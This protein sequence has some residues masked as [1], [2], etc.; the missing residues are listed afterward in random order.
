MVFLRPKLFNLL[1]FGVGVG[2]RHASDFM[3]IFGY[4]LISQKSVLV[5]RQCDYIHSVLYP[6]LKVEI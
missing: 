5:H 6:Y 1:Y 4:H 3:E 2:I